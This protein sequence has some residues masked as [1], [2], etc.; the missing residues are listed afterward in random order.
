MVLSIFSSNLYH[1]TFPCRWKNPF[2]LFS[3]YQATGHEY[4]PWSPWCTCF[5]TS[6]FADTY[7][8]GQLLWPEASGKEC[9]IRFTG[10]TSAL[11]SCNQTRESYNCTW[12]ATWWSYIIRLSL[13]SLWYTII[14]YHKKICTIYYIIFK[15][16]ISSL[17]NISMK[18]LLYSL[19]CKEDAWC[20]ND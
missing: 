18:Y 4:S 19:W 20:C 7:T 15:I 13:S 2:F 8:A 1:Q 17:W 14:M 3:L 11:L 16:E 12:I 5:H 6:L 10:C 9:R